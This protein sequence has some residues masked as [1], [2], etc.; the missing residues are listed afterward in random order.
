[1]SLGNLA[2]RKLAWRTRGLCYSC[3]AKPTR[4][5]KLCERHLEY[6]R[7]YR[8]NLRA[9]RRRAGKCMECERLAVKSR[10][11]VRHWLAH[12]DAVSGCHAR[13]V[14]GNLAR[15]RCVRCG[16]RSGGKW[17]CRTHAAQREGARKRRR[18]RQAVV[19][20]GR[21]AGTRLL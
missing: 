11:C 19:A 10:Y 7:T 14:A 6:Q 9:Q 13:R 15:G 16:A 5:H 2:E 17:Y 18:Q 1:M 12:R 20:N 3:G 8:R 4:G 21:G